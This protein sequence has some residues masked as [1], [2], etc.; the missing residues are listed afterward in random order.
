MSPTF[1]SL[2]N[3]N[4]RLWASGAIVSNVGTWMQRVAQDWLVLA[5]LTPNSGVALGVTTGLQFAP[6]LLL[7]PVAGAAADRWNRR[8][9]LMATQ[10]SSGLL[11]LVLGLLVVTREAQLWQ[12]YLLAGL[13]GVVA[14]FDA[15]ARQAFVTELVPA[16]DLSNAVGL[17]SASFH[18]GRLI[19][20]GIA[21]L[22][23]HWFGTGPVFLLNAASFGAVLL[24]L[25]R[26][27]PARLCPVARTA[28]RGGIREGLRYVGGR[29]DLMLVMSIVGMVGTFGLNFQLSTALMARLVFHRGSG[30]YGLLGSTLAVGSLAGSLL[31]ARRENPR[32]QLVVGATFAF[33]VLASVAA[34][35]PGYPLFALAL[36]PVGVCTQTLLTA[37]NSTVQ[38]STA[39]ELRGRVMALYMA[40]LMGGT[41]VGAP[42]VGWIGQT[43]GARWTIL[44][45]AAAAGL[46]AVLAWLWLAR[47]PSPPAA[48]QPGPQLSVQPGGVAEQLVA[49][50]GDG[51]QQGVRD[52]QR[53][54]PAAAAEPLAEGEAHHGVAQE[55]PESLVEVVAAAQDGADPE[56]E[57]GR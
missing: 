53:H 31:G 38:L 23:I 42:L 51:V 30:E 46:T 1:R 10:A 25:A 3:V 44:L 15:P 54:H 5:V 9:L 48:G 12:V 34:V 45:G 39:P 8:R 32:I 6:V 52:D 4:Y 27:D 41:P 57:P 14:A 20:P 19:G 36:I 2:R 18:A 33:A 40:V 49:D 17:N 56:G 16:E 37:A 50:E 35:M 13:L 28:R 21:G 24:S 26:M 7:A 55:G 47:H 29:P 11:A 22:L 43:F